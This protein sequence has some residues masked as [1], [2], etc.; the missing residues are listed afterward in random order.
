MQTEAGRPRLRK[1]SEKIRKPLIPAVNSPIHIQNR[2][3][4]RPKVM[5]LAG[6]P[7]SL[8]YIARG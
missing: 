7:V 8:K 6:S 5:R 4:K 3:N 2:Q 1:K